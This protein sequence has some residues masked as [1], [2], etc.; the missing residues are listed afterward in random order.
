MFKL[1]WGIRCLLI[2]ILMQ[3]S[4][5]LLAQYPTVYI[6]KLFKGTGTGYTLSGNSITVGPQISGENFRFVGAIAGSTYTPSGNNVNG[7]IVYTNAAGSQITLANGTISGVGPSSGGIRKY[8]NF[9]QLASDEAYIFVNPK[10]DADILGSSSYQFNASSPLTDLNSFLSAQTIVNVAA[11]LSGFTSCL[12]NP[13]NAQTFTVSGSNL[14]SNISIIAPTGF[15]VSF[16][17]GSGYASSISLLKGTGTSISAT[18]IYVRLSSA[19]AAGSFSGNLVVSATNSATT[20]VNTFGEVFT[21]PAISG[22]PTNTSICTG[23]AGNFSVTASGG[24][25]TYQWQVNSGSGWSNLSNTGIYYGTTTSVLRI[26]SGVNTSYNAYQYRCVVSGA[27]TPAVNSNAATLTVNSNV[28]IQTQPSNVTV[29]VGSATSLSVNATGTGLTYQWQVFLNGTWS[30]I[31]NTGIYSGAT[32]QT[33]SLSSTSNAQNSLQYK[34]NIIGTCSSSTSNV[35]TLTVNDVPNT[36]SSILGDLTICENTNQ[37][38]SVA[39]ISGATS[40]TWMIPSGWSGTST[41]RAI[42]VTASTIGGNILVQ[43]NNSCGSSSAVQITIA[44][45]NNPAPVVDFGINAASQC[46]TNNS[47][48]FTNT[49]TTQV[50]VSISSNTWS[51]GDGTTD[52]NT[53]AA[54]SFLSANTYSVNLRVVASNGCI[55]SKSSFIVVNPAPTSSISGSQTICSGSTASLALQFTG[56]QPWNISYSDGTTTSTLSNI[57]TSN[58]TLNVTPSTSKTYTISQVS[59]ANC[60]TTAVGDRTGSA[61][62]TVNPM[63][64]ASVSVTSNDADNSVCLGTSI[65]FTATPSNGGTPVYSWQKNGVDIGVGGSSFSVNSNT[66]VDDDVFS[67]QMTSN[68]TCVSRPV[69]FSNAITLHIAPGTPR[70]PTLISGETTQCELGV[71]KAYSIVDV[72]NATSYNWSLPSGWAVTSGQNS[73]QVLVNVGS[74]NQVGNISVSAT[75]GCGTSTAQ[76]LTITAVNASPVA[77][78]AT[79]TQSFCSNTSPTVAALTATGTSIKWYNSSGLSSVLSSTAS[80]SSGNYYVTQTASG[81]ESPSSTISVIVTVNP[82]ITSSIAGSN[83]GPGAIT[84]SASA[85]SGSLNW[86][87]GSSGGTALGSLTSYTTPIISATTTYY[88]EAISNACISASRTAV[89]A[90]I[91]AIPTISSTSPASV[92][93][94]GTVA[95]SAVAS[96]GNLNWYDAS[97]GGNLVASNVNSFT[98]ASLSTSRNYYVEANNNGCLSTS[99]TAILASVVSRPTLVSTTPA[100]RCGSGAVTIG[101]TSSSGSVKWYNATSGGTLLSTGSSFTT[102]SISSTTTYYAEAEDQGCSSASRTSVDASILTIPNVVSVSNGSRCGDGVVALSASPSAGTLNWY[103]VATGGTLISSN[104]T[105]TTPSLTTTTTYYVEASQNGCTSSRSAVV[106]TVTQVPITIS[107][108]T[109]DYDVV[110]LTASGGTSYNWNGGNSLQSASNSFDE[111]GDYTV[112]VSDNTGCVSTRTVSVRIKIVGL[113]RYGNISEDSLMQV[114]RFGERAGNNPIVKFGGLKKYKKYKMYSQNLVFYVNP[115]DVNSYSGAGSTWLDLSTNSNHGTLQN[116]VMFSSAF[117]GIFNF[118]GINDFVSVANGLPV[119]NS[120]TIDVWL[121]LENVTG[122]KSILSQDGV[123][124]GAFQLLIEDSILKFALRGE[125]VKSANYQIKAKQWV[126]VTTVFNQANNTIKF[127]FDGNLVNTET[128]TNAPTIPNVTFKIGSFEGTSS[129]LNGSIGSLRV[130]SSLLNENQVNANFQSNK[131]FYGL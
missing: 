65:T 1:K 84:L 96:T 29:C 9:I 120:M 58:Y 78:T 125:Q 81:C 123:G 16:S 22:Q 30:N 67:V 37:S 91:F 60:S 5:G 19:N 86:Y 79:T 33:L 92:C 31:S 72:L 109:T 104:S 100:N 111:S 129:F 52:L 51:F 74:A 103:S 14:S 17:S 24:N 85:S 80:L 73:T 50:G 4:V 127:Y 35:G 2:C 6:N 90:T 131:D 53:N 82:T 89:N 8:F 93:G 95:L 25:L 77:P 18:T 62:V 63:V 55:S 38:Y 124:N 47:F 126:H 11:N 119:T 21:A 27:C 97:T 39:S 70:T 23:T 106:A 69:V 88:V 71:G 115:T 64:N 10:Y 48:S 105:Y 114:N 87:A 61:I 98:T 45:S 49:T 12:G 99:R 41:Q 26:S 118:D 46:L 128:Y 34:C 57:S 83:C 32:T 56:T 28:S 122:I 66:L 102:S 121:N 130:Y 107:G 36:P 94:S 20:N 68:A 15:E 44:V 3:V 108:N 76:I 112:S 59:D 40:Y 13:S 7:S 113:D 54:H 117:G 101:A 116:G 75:N 42:N 110:S 43:A